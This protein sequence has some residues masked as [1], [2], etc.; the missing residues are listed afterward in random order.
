MA[1]KKSKYS[2]FIYLGKKGIYFYSP[3]CLYQLLR[4]NPHLPARIS[5]LPA[6]IGRA[7]HTGITRV[8]RHYLSIR[9]RSGK[10]S[11]GTSRLTPAKIKKGGKAAL[12]EATRM[13]LFAAGSGI[14]RL[15]AA[16]PARGSY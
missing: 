13:T 16:S 7:I 4:Y 11:Q 9:R 14:T 2:Y 15:P 10:L 5:N 12:D 6:R 8:A 1:K 3:S